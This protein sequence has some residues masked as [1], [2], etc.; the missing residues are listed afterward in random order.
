MY[1]NPESFEK[2][3]EQKNAKAE[4]ERNRTLVDF[5]RIP[6]ELVNEFKKDC[7]RL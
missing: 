6:E 7:L 1:E 5:N 3:I 4:Y 2:R